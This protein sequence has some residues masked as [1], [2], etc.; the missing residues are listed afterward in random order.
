MEIWAEQMLPVMLP[1]GNIRPMDP[2]LFFLAL[3]GRLMMTVIA[4]DLMRFPNLQEI[5]NEALVESLVQTTLARML[6]HSMQ[7]EG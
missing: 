1:Q 6:T 5:T 2:R 4:R 7:Q 3:Q